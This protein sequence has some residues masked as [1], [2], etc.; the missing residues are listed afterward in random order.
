MSEGSQPSRSEE[1]PSREPQKIERSRLYPQ[2]FAIRDINSYRSDCQFYEIKN[3]EIRRD[4]IINAA[5]CK[6]LNRYLTI[7]EAIYCIKYWDRCPYRAVHNVIKRS[8]SP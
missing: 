8:S 3:V 4:V 6:I 2:I 5:Y 1:S 7:Y